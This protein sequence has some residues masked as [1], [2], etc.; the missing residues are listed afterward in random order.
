MVSW[1]TRKSIREIHGD[2]GESQKGG[3]GTV[4]EVRKGKGFGGGGLKLGFPEWPMRDSAGC[5]SKKRSFSCSSKRTEVC[6]AQLGEVEKSEWK[7]VCC[8]SRKTACMLV[9]S[10]AAASRGSGM[11]CET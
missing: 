2:G 3:E 6:E 1:K 4:M 5:A 8:G 7:N 9:R 11:S 10:R